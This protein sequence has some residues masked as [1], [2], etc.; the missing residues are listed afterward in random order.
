M[1]KFSLILS[2]IAGVACS[3]FAQA[4]PDRQVIAKFSDAGIQ[5]GNPRLN[6]I[7]PRIDQELLDGAL[8]VYRVPA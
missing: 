4:G 8:K 1:R 3:A 2:L 5:Q 6:R 7:N